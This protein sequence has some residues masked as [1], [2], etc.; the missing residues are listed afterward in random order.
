MKQ[1]LKIA[2]DVDQ[3]ICSLSG[4]WM[5]WLKERSH[6]FDKQQY[7]EDLL[8]GTTNYNLSK[9]Y[10]LH[11]GV[12]P[13]GFWEGSDIY[14]KVECYPWAKIVLKELYEE[15]HEILFV[16]YCFSGHLNSKVA[17][18]RREFNFIKEEDFHFIATKSKGYVDC[19]VIID[20]RIDMLNQF[21]DKSILKLLIHTPYTQTETEADTKSPTFTIFDWKNVKEFIN[22]FT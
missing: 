16:S 8:A 18:L 19:D 17:M 21:K 7:V 15:G 10:E 4:D 5:L 12:N 13:M 3:C 1:N 14:D 20:D 6:S 22:M 2:V 11:E 9:Y